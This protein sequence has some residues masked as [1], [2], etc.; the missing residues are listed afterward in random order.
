MHTFPTSVYLLYPFVIV[1]N[2]VCRFCRFFLFHNWGIKSRPAHVLWIMF[3][4]LPVLLKT[5]PRGMPSATFCLWL[6]S[7]ERL[8]V[9]SFVSVWGRGCAL[10]VRVC[11][12][13]IGQLSDLGLGA[14]SI[15][16]NT[17]P[18]NRRANCSHYLV[19]LA[20]PVPTVRPQPILNPY[21]KSYYQRARIT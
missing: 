17:A 20:R 1:P 10:C 3:Y 2:R 15:A 13:Y 12:L 21:K 8:F 4:V 16:F 7:L 5:R 19:P 11:L 6:N 18:L 14:S 9:C